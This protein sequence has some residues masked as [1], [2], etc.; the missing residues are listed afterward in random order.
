[1][2]VEVGKRQ[3]PEERYVRNLAR[4]G[5]SMHRYRRHITGGI[6]IAVLSGIG[7]ILYLAHMEQRSNEAWP[8][9]AAMDEAEDV[10]WTNDVAMGTDAEFFYI[11]EAGTLLFERGEKEDL[12]KAEELYRRFCRKWRRHP[13][14]PYAKQSLGCVL[15]QQDRYEDAMKE[16]AA[17]AQ[18]DG[19]LTAQSLWD[20]GRCAE[21]AGKVDLARGFYMRL[22]AMEDASPWTEYA[23]ARLAEILS[24][25]SR[26]TEPKENAV[27]ENKTEP[28]KKAEPEK[29]AEPEKKAV[30][31]KKEPEKEK[32][33]G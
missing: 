11:M 6:L 22:T 23:G 26:K 7:L 4:Y 17:L 2:K 32:T 8:A 33:D 29:E 28:E 1:M 9:V 24:D 10:K 18:E 30:P 15:E 19:P 13:A 21:N 14:A 20:A 3:L 12:E 16:F 25:K 31:E 5:T 27:P